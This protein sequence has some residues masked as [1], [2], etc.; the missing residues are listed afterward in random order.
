MTYKIKF[1]CFISIM[2]LAL[3]FVLVFSP[4]SV[5]ADTAPVINITS[6]ANGATPSDVSV[7]FSDFWKVW[8]LLKGSQV[9]SKS[10][11]DQQLLYGA[12]SG[13]AGA[14]NDPYTVFFNP[15]DAKEFLGDVQG[16]FGGIGAEL[17]SQNG[18]MVVI[19]PLKDSPAAAA[20][21]ENGDQIL[22]INSIS[23][24]NMALD[25]AV[26]LIRG[27][28]G[29][30]V[31]LT[32]LRTSWTASKIITITRA[33]INIPTVDWS[34]KNGNVMYL[35]LDEFD[36]N[37]N[38][39]FSNAVTA[40]L[41]QGAKGMI[42]DL[43]ND[44]G[45][46][47]DQA[48]DIAGWFVS[49]GTIVVKEKFADN[50][51]STL[52]ANG[53]ATLKNFPL[54]ILINNGSASASEILSGALRVDKGAKLIGD[55]SFGKGSVQQVT[56]LADGSAVKITV[57]KWLLPDNGAIDHVGLT[58]DYLVPIT[59][60]DVAAKIDSQLDK[61]LQVISSEIVQ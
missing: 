29:T 57:A 3:L 10:V 54:V 44:P 30:S 13:L 56:Q 31:N 6:I 37:A 38:Q 52:T 48:V 33:T 59:A 39:L 1:N 19:A 40:G 50:T 9:D 11:S 42:L 21:I 47:L 51:V 17:G 58:P 32:I 22:D 16:S 26:Q 2:F 14:Y 45:G 15:N 25:K 35:Q 60:A 12:I 34:M 20:G 41:A 23:T 4:H 55:K 27:N 36:A 7:D 53:N 43:R 28:P 5:L 49:P 18:Q 24:T 46:Y 8:N 61:A